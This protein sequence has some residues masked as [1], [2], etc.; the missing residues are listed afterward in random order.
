MSR[1]DAAGYADLRPVHGLVFQALRG[2]GA[3]SSEPAEKLGVTEQAAGQIVDDL[4]KR[5]HVERRPRPAGG[6]RRQVVLTDRAAD[7]PDRGRAHPA[8]A[9]RRSCPSRSGRRTWRCRGR[10][11]PP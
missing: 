5:G 9:W 6:R 7:P 10:N 1:P 8:R 2:D 3:T 11:S 4:E